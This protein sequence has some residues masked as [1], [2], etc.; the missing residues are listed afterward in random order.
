ME[1][2]LEATCLRLLGR[3]GEALPAVNLRSQE[4]LAAYSSP[5]WTF[6][7]SAT[8]LSAG[9]QLILATR[10]D[11]GGLGAS[12]PYP[13][14]MVLKRDQNDLSRVI[15]GSGAGRASGLIPAVSAPL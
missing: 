13:C 5:V 15:T 1:V 4:Q 9:W 14:L 10:G 8:A 3:A 2:L 6:H 11:A 12:L 7:E